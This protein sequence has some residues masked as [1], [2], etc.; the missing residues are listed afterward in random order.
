ML[1]CWLWNTSG[2][3]SVALP[4]DPQLHLM[5]TLVIALPTVTL[6]VTQLHSIPALE[7]PYKQLPRVWVDWRGHTPG[8]QEK[9]PKSCLARRKP[10]VL[11]WPTAFLIG[12]QYVPRGWPDPLWWPQ[13]GSFLAKMLHRSS[14]EVHALVKITSAKKLCVACVRGGDCPED[15]KPLNAVH[16]AVSGHR[17]PLSGGDS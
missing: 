6:L 12:S 16:L 15:T 4:S 2:H 13:E 1:S 17:E 11:G 10:D 8:D 7:S 14:G 5:K 3:L 9:V